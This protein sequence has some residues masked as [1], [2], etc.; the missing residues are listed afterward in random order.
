M[1]KR[2]AI[3]S[4]MILSGFKETLDPP[5]NVEVIVISYQAGG[6]IVAQLNRCS[7]DWQAPG[8]A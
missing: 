2:C 5:D 6:E 4:R 8:H 3:N 7:S 1:E